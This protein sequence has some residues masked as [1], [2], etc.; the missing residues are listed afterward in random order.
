LKRFRFAGFGG[1]GV[2]LC[3]YIVGKAAM[4]DG[5]NSI[6]TQSY[7]SA[8]R[9]GLTRS[10]VAISD[11]EIYDLINDELDLL[12]AM[13]QQ[14]YEASASMLAPEGFLFYESDLVKPA[15]DH[16]SRAYGFPATDT[17]FKSFGRKIIANI[18]M[19]GFA[20]AITEVVTHE[21]LAATIRETV[22]PGTEDKNIAALEEGMRIGRKMA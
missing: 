20:N 15:G 22:P 5:L 21:S 10:D 14:S 3:G 2:V 19:I 9:G 16:G 18:M 12:V 1:Q 13:S 4:L 7:G 17:A 8:S 6:H 11:G